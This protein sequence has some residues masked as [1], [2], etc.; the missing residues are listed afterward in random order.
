MPAKIRLARHGR[1]K[2]AFYHIVVADGRAPRDGKFI[3][4][5]GIYNPMTAPATIELDRQLA[6]DWLMKGAQPTDTARAILRFKG[7]YY[8]K[9][10]QRGVKKGALTQEEADAKLTSWIEEKE[11]KVAER[12]KA[13][14]QAKLDWRKQVADGVPKSKLAPATSELEDFNQDQE[15]DG[16]TS[17]IADVVAD[18]SQTTKETL[19][20]SSDILEVVT[21]SSVD[22]KEAPVVAEEKSGASEDK[23]GAS[24]EKSATTEETSAVSEEIST[25]SEEKSGASEE[26]PE[27]PAKDEP[28]ASAEEE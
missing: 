6:Y 1:R 10:L 7:V 22:E 27:E 28:I 24:D 11:A 21:E 18:S 5:L 4:K 20:T 13:A 8:K 23:S 9:H 12:R 26:S 19:E 25:S 2:N 16:L 17:E 3:K 15:T 14:I